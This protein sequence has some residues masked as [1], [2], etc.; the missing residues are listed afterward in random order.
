M[1][2]YTGKSKEEKRMEVK[3][4]MDS[5]EKGVTSVFT[6]EKYQECLDFF[7]KFHNY[8]LNN[9]ILIMMQKPD[10]T[11]VA[12]FAT[13]KKLGVKINK[14]AKGIKILCP[15][16]YKYTEEQDTKDGGKKEVEKSGLYFKVGHVFDISQ[17]D[18]ELPTLTEKIKGNSDE[19]KALIK[20]I[21][22]GSDVPIVI[23]K[24]LNDKPENGYYDLLVG[25]IHVK[26]NLED[27]HKLK[28]II[29]E[30]AHS[31]LHADGSVDRKEAEVQAESV[32]YVVCKWLNLDTSD[33]SFGYVAGWSSSKETKELKKSLDTIE[34]TAKNMIKQIE[35]Y[36]G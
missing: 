17:T 13:W 4:I 27:A 5:L 20:K 21:I 11:K 35:K 29:H 8:S 34:K 15:V 28:T 2:K 24:E 36:I 33:Y 1:A 31:K 30:L 14:G 32:A 10:A 12:S 9:T 18:G 23:D 26:E 22:G 19:L 3:E 16:P 25:D 6:S 7:S